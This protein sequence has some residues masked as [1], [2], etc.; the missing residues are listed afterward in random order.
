MEKPDKEEK[1][2][3]QGTN[4]IDF[5]LKIT[6]DMQNK[7]VLIGAKVTIAGAASVQYSKGIDIGTICE[8][9]LPFFIWIQK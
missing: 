7:Q 8:K 4:T 9:S 6:A 5:S 2:A 3:K 1:D